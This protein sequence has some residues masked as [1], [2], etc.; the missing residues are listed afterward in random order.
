MRDPVHF[1]LFFWV[2]SMDESTLTQVLSVLRER[3]K[4]ME[5]YQCVSGARLHSAHVRP[6]GVQADIPIGLMFDVYT[7]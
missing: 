5:F 1:C 4:L 3:E 2:Q 7:F 6:G